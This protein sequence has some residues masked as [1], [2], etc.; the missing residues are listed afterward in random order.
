MNGI[1]TVINAR[2]FASLRL[3]TNLLSDRFMP[4]RARQLSHIKPDGHK[5]SKYS[6]QILCTARPHSLHS[7]NLYMTAHPVWINQPINQTLFRVAQVEQPL[8]G[9]LNNVKRYQ[10]MTA[11]I[12]N[13]LTVDGKLTVNLPQLHHLAVYSRCEKF[14]HKGS[15][16][17]RWKSDCWYQYHEYHEAVGVETQDIGLL[18]F[19]W[20]HITWHQH[21]IMPDRT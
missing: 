4:L 6:T 7:M 13:V 20:G 2:Q 8:Q 21:N 11:A 15:A 12:I 18:M 5:C 17:N 9:P 14:N 19:Y 3:A 10:D 1:I 16:D